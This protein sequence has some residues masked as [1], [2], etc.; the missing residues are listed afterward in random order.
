[1]SEQSPAQSV[2]D[3]NSPHL[4][5]SAL[6]GPYQIFTEGDA[7]YEAMLADIKSAKWQV[8]LE[9]YIFKE[10]R[11]GRVFIDE[12]CGQARSGVAVIVR[13]DAFGSYGAISS[14]AIHAMRQSGVDFAWSRTWYWRR[15]WQYH[16]RNH[17]KLL[18]ID[19]R[20][21]YVGGFNIC[22]EN[23]L[24]VFGELR[25]RDTHIRLPSTFVGEAVAAFWD[26]HK[27]WRRWRPDDTR[28]S[29]LMTNYGRACRYRLRCLFNNR[30]EAA[31]QR[32]WLTSPY[33]VPDHR[34]QMRLKEAAR[35]GVDVRLLVPAKSDVAL[36]QWAAAAS[37][38]NLIQAGVKI[39]EYQRRVMHA[40]TIIIDDDWSTVGTSNIDYR[41][42]FLNYE[43]NFISVFQPLN[44]VL[45]KIFRSD[46]CASEEIIESAW[47]RRP[48]L[49]K[50]AE[51]VGW[52]A[53]RWL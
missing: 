32:I 28:D 23:S 36:A 8:I 18:V 52:M 26:F 2:A 1:M 15:L 46:L 29:Y 35:R 12:L 16:R 34:T 37:Y 6:A 44:Q 38:A 4:P 33:F 30:F 40:K 49:R 11:V 17:R 41:S 21:A 10:D 19:E 50:F 51:M 7:L 53:R 22:D 45:Y 27:G 42:F 24:V 5:P 43:L 48:L 39:Y 20:A 13:I 3:N 31:R 47:S 9:S 14:R 25:W